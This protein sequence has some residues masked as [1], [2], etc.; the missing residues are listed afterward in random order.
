MPEAVPT[1]PRLFLGEVLKRLRAESGKKTE[2]L[3][4]AIGKDRGQMSRVLDGKGTLSVD[5]LAQLLDVLGATPDQK[6]ELLALGAEARKRPTRRPYTD[7]LPRSYERL[8]DLE[9]MA[10]EIWSYDPGIIPG[11][12]QIPEYIEALMT[13]GDGIWWESSWE[14]RRN[15]ISFR[16]ERQKLMMVAD[17]PKSLRFILTDTALRTEVGGPDVMRRQ[18][19]HLLRMIDERPDTAIQILSAT[20][21]HNPAQGGGGLAL[22]HFGQTLRP[23]GFLHGFYGPSTYFDEPIDT[24]RLFRAFGRLEALAASADESRRVIADLVTRS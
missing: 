6:R 15:R 10:T 5:E 9:S 19:E 1:F 23:V 13:D 18:L 20:A 16:L 17:P 8:A 4:V 12:L 3:A 24:G 7:L 22:L 14:E 2:D 21:A 11:P